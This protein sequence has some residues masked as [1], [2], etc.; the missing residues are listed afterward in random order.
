MVKLEEKKQIRDITGYDDQQFYGQ[1]LLVLIK[2]M[3]LLL[4]Y[5]SIYK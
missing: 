3:Y 2:V 1:I 4:N 5:A